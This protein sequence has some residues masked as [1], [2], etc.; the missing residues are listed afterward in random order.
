MELC[1]SDM[2]ERAGPH[3]TKGLLWQSPACLYTCVSLGSCRNS[4]KSMIGNNRDMVSG[5][6]WVNFA[7]L[8]VF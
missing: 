5:F 2:N 3:H 4:N 6:L 7:K 8:K 1:L